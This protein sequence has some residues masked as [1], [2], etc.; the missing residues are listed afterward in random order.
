MRQLTFVTT[1]GGLQ[2]PLKNGSTAYDPNVIAVAALPVFLVMTT[3]AQ[4]KVKAKT[5]PA[6]GP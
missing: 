3:A 1:S 4:E 5:G 6:R 2:S